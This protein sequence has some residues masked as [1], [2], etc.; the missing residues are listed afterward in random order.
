MKYPLT[1]SEGEIAVPATALSVDPTY[2]C[3]NRYVERNSKM[4]DRKDQTYTLTIT[5]LYVDIKWF[6]QWTFLPEHVRYYI[7]IKTAR[8][9]QKRYLADENLHR[10]NQQDEDEAKS[11]FDREEL[12]IGD[13][14]LLDN[15]RVNPRYYHRR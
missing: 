12:K 3:D 8:T 5:T 2:L 7:T 14:S 6:L 10:F 1:A 4:Y 11:E 13:F 15:T 9:F